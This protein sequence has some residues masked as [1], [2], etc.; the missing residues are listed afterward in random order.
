MKLLKIFLLSLCL[1]VGGQVRADDQTVESSDKEINLQLQEAKKTINYLETALIVVTVAYVII[2]IMGRRRL[3]RKILVRNRALK[4]ALNKAKEVDLLKTAFIRN[5]SHEIRTPLTAINGFSQ[6]LCNPEY[7][8]LSLKEK[9]GMAE[10]ITRDVKTITGIVEELL[11]MSAGESTPEEAPVDVNNLCRRMM[12]EVKRQNDK[13]LYILYDTE[14]DDDFTI[15]SSEKNLERILR[16]ILE[17]ALK[18]TEKGS[19]TMH[20]AKK[21][22]LLQISVA[23]TGIGIDPKQRE[24]IFETFFQLNQNVN[25]VGLGLTL[26]RRLARMLGGDVVLDANYNKGSRFLITLPLK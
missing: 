26:S 14:L 9:Q 3:M 6:L 13:G 7:E 11:D 24:Q 19:I 18:F 12:E 23:D 16:R 10:R 5:M 20:C 22:G 17:N 15:M 2:Y 1:F 4:M 25:G 21:D 8:S